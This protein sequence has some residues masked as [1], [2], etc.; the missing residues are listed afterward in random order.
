MRIG[1]WNGEQNVAPEEEH[2]TR[3]VLPQG[4]KTEE[5][6]RGD[7]DERLLSPLPIRRIGAQL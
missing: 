6:S 3:A 5:F 4:P 7:A 1:V 2:A